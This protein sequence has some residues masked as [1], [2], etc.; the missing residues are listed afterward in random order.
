M[1][2]RA[3][4]GSAVVIAENSTALLT[5]RRAADLGARRILVQHNHPFGEFLRILEEERE[6]WGGPPS[7]ITEELLE[8]AGKEPSEADLVVAFSCSVADALARAG[9]DRER[10]RTLHFGV[11]AAR[12]A[13]SGVPV[14][15]FTVTHVGWL[16]LRKGY[17]YL[18]EGFREA[19]I[20]GSRLLLHG[21]SDL[22]FHHDLV[23]S[24]KGGADVSVVRG[25]VEGTFRTA[26]VAVLPSVSDGYG[27]AALEAMACGLPVVVTSACGVAQD[28]VEGVNGFVVPPRDPVALRDRLL[29]LRDPELRVRMGAAARET[30]LRHTW[31]SFRASI[32]AVTAELMPGDPAAR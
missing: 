12:F 8:R 19:R 4:P 21:G 27:M 14:G 31:E 30:A 1:A 6:A 18:V 32:A 22:R 23:A 13:P 29:A 2:A 7:F 17:P 15:P 11:D 24:L 16:D 9:V 20:P 3:L 28:V 10:V 5:L 25:P 26:S